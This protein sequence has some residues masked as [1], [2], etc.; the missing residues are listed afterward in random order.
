MNCDGLSASGG[1][2]AR[3]GGFVGASDCHRACAGNCITFE[4]DEW[5][6][7]PVVGNASAREVGRRHLCAA[8]HGH[9]RWTTDRRWRGVRDGVLPAFSR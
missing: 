2:A 9:S 6:C 7:I 3:V 8:L 5:V 1:I 4:R